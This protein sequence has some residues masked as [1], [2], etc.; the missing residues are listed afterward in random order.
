[1]AGLGGCTCRDERPLGSATM[2]GDK[3]LSGMSLNSGVAQ[4]QTHFHCRAERAAERIAR[5]PDTSDGTVSDGEVDHIWAEGISWASDEVRTKRRI[6]CSRKTTLHR[7]SPIS[8][9]QQCSRD[10]CWL[11]TQPTTTIPLSHLQQRS[12]SSTRT[13]H[14]GP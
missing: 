3:P 9:Y 14:M 13:W 1:M 6:P 12:F 11:A 2:Q 5:E 4:R 8:I 10:S 7:R